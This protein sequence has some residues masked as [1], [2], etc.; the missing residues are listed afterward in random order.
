MNSYLRKKLYKYKQNKYLRFFYYGLKNIFK[1][2]F[3]IWFWRD[4]FRYKK[5]NKRFRIPFL[6]LWPITCDKTEYTN[7]DGHYTYFPAWAIRK[8]LEIKKIENL[9][10][11]VDFSSSLHF[12]SNLSA[13]L[14]V[15]FYDYRPA[16]LTLS[17]LKSGHADLVNLKNFK[18][19]SIKSLSCMHVIEHIGLGI[20]G[21]ELDTEGDIKA[22][23]EIKRVCDIGGNILFVVPV[24]KERI[25]FNAHRIYSFE[26]IKKLFGESFELKEFSLI[27]DKN[28]F[29]ENMGAEEAKNLIEKQKYGCGCFYFIKK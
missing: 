7:F 22:I 5:E 12:S 1:T 13:F 19:N 2:I 3:D 27:T 16:N 26:T 6:E 8:V 23:N 20:Y 24:G 18:D 11:H 17:N 25:Q 14:P 29:I 9:E 10:K 21:D 15:E 4:Y 28:E